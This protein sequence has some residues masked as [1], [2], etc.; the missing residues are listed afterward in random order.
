MLGSAHLESR[1]LLDEAPAFPWLH[2]HAA[3][4]APC[5]SWPIRR[6]ATGP[7][8]AGSAAAR[9]I[10]SSRLPFTTSATGV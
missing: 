6:R 3:Y 1:D 9:S 4:R 10:R 2:A 5:C 7:S 8:T